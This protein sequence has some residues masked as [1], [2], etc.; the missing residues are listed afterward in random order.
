M[1]DV[2]EKYVSVCPLD[3][4]TFE[5]Y[6]ECNCTYGSAREVWWFKEQKIKSLE[7]EVARLKEENLRMRNWKNCKE[8]DSCTKPFAAG[9]II[10][11]CDRWEIKK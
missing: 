11:P 9:V 1:S 6:M 8:Q 7:Q 4:S 2:P 3:H 10:C 5:K